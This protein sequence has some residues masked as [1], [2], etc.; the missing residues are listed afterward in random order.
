M[1]ESYAA[2][3]ESGVIPE[4]FASLPESINQIT[5]EQL[6][7]IQILKSDQIHQLLA[8]RD[9]YGMILS[10][11][12]LQQIPGITPQIISKLGE[13]ILFEEIPFDDHG[14]NTRVESIDVI[15][16]ARIQNRDR[17]TGI[18]QRHRIRVDVPGYINIDIR[19]D[20]D[21][22]EKWRFNPPD[23][24]GF[25]HFSASATAS[26]RGKLKTLVTG[27]FRVHA[28]QGLV[29]NAAFRM[30]KGAG[31]P[32]PALSG[33]VIP[34]GSFGETGRLT[35]AAAQVTFSKWNCGFY[36]SHRAADASLKEDGTFTALSTSGLHRTAAEIRKR[37]AI[38]LSSAGGFAEYSS[39]NGLIG[40]I[41]NTD[42]ISH[43]MRHSS[44][45]KDVLP[46]GKYFFQGS[47]YG[48]YSY[49][50]VL[51]WF[52]IA[53]LPSAAH[54]LLAGASLAIDRHIETL[55]IFR[56]YDPGY[57]S[58]NGNAFGEQSS[59]N[60]N[61]EGIYLALAYTP[62]K[63]WRISAYTDI[64]RFPWYSYRRNAGL[65][66]YDVR[67]D[68]EFQFGDF[69]IR[70]F[71]K[72]EW[73]SSIQGND[74]IRS[75]R[76]RVQVHIYKTFYLSSE[77]R[78]RLQANKFTSESETSGCLASVDYIL[79]LRRTQWNFRLM[80][81]NSLNYQTREFISERDVWGAFSLPSYYGKGIR[82]VFMVRIKLGPKLTT[83]IRYAV[84]YK[85]KEI[86]DQELKLQTKLTI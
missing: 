70:A 42:F 2:S 41:F 13:F 14:K 35:G 6:F 80:Y 44:E 23:Q 84:T 18:S 58:F 65:T 36:I 5:E 3:K 66:G 68:G 24:W 30:G 54:A 82:S 34:S 25:D 7:A 20:H 48:N 21:A 71:Y 9:R 52:E 75:Q 12:E 57:F 26:F 39:D 72:S 51:T 15:S 79:N 17:N 78:L 29:Q 49:R 53:V 64:Y 19:T 27:N 32:L 62:R 73:Q 81:F 10:K 63:K 28:G 56:S 1:A 47:I 8:Y 33:F 4:V 77:I 40:T 85:I 37:N 38:K 11:Y 76:R 83:W 59:M 60:R 22:G 69:R 50:N 74:G 16:L 43:P 31:L 46:Q 67:L 55:L 61:E 86:P 45:Y